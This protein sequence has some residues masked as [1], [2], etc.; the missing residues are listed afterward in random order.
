MSTISVVIPTY[1]L[2]RDLETMA[3][4]CAKGYREFADELIIC[5]DGGR[6][7][8]DLKD[9]ADLYINHDN[10]GFTANLNNGWLAAKGDYAFLVNS[11]TY[12]ESVNYNDL[13]IHGTVTSPN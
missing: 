5:E 10:W 9:L 13:C 4:N 1:S 2:N 3:I 6:Y 8:K 12:I 7:S 11:Y